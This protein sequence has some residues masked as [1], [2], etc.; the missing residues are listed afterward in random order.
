MTR[1]ITFIVGGAA[2][3]IVAL[4]FVIG[5]RFASPRPED[6]LTQ[7]RDAAGADGIAATFADRDAK[8]WHIPAGHQVTR[9]ALADGQVKYVRFASAVP[10]D[11]KAT[12]WAER[13]LS[14]SLPLAFTTQTA[15]RT[16]EIGVVARAAQVKAAPVLS[17]VYAT[18]Q[19]G[20][21]GWRKIKLAAEF[22]LTTLTYDVPSA[23]GGYKHPPIIVLNADPSGGG[24][25]I[26]LLALYVRP[27]P[28]GR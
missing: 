24:R 20:N 13:G 10:L 28:A 26:E 22:G 19:A 17:V 25:A 21:S 9:F 6:L 2:I 4:A 5:S 11:N 27:S 18:Q 8:R 7:A 15:G 3:A 14:L 1:T 12:A 23:A 16:I